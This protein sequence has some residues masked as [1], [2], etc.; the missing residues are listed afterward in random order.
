[1]GR[2]LNN[3][4]LIEVSG[5][6]F[7]DID[8]QAFQSS[9]IVGDFS[10]EP[11]PDPVDADPSDGGDLV[12]EGSGIDDTFLTLK[13]AII[14]RDQNGDE[15]YIFNDVSYGNDEEAWLEAIFDY[16]VDEFDNN[17]S[18]GNHLVN[19]FGWDE[20]GKLIFDLMPA[21]VQRAM[22]EML[23]TDLPDNFS[24]ND[25]DEAEDEDDYNEEGDY[26]TYIP[27]GDDDDGD[28]RS[29]SNEIEDEDEEYEQ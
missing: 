10:F 9:F 21:S 27:E 17:V 15:L 8:M 4:E 14:L 23:G 26:G 11:D 18:A 7:S 1:M 24:D 12:G 29:W 20:L 2:L 3:N 22:I 16:A 6:N 25:E 28:G 5:G 19:F 13:T